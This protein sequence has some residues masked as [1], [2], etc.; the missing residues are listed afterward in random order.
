M[1]YSVDDGVHFRMAKG[2]RASLSKLTLGT[3]EFS[4]LSLAQASFWVEGGGGGGVEA[5]GEGGVIHP[6]V[7]S[8][9]SLFCPF[10]FCLLS[11]VSCFLFFQGLRRSW[12]QPRRNGWF[13]YKVTLN[14]LFVITH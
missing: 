6:R 4:L 8:Q 1:I 9:A 5:E 14:A 10:V 2:K 13:K 7:S 11:A 12:N 3:P